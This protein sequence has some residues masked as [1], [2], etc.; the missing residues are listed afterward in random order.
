MNI[1]ELQKLT[2]ALTADKKE[3]QKLIDEINNEAKKVVE[4]YVKNPSELSG[5][6]IQIHPDSPLLDKK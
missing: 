5:S 4:D 1:K 3:L 2:E 6:T